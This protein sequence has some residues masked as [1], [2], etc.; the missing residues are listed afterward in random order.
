M[1][2]TMYASF[3]LVLIYAVETKG[4]SSFSEPIGIYED[5]AQL[6][7]LFTIH[8]SLVIIN[9]LIYEVPC[10]CILCGRNLAGDTERR[11]L[12]G[13]SENRNLAGD[14]ERRNLGG[15]SENRNLAGD[16]E[17]RNLGGDSENRNLAGDTERR[18]LGGDSEN[19]NLA[20]DTENRN[21]GGS[22]ESRNLAGDTENRNLGGNSETR[23]L[24]GNSENRNLAGQVTELNCQNISAEAFRITGINPNSKI[25]FYD[26][27]HLKSIENLIVKF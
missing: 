24:G 15:D 22:S 11:N 25:L 19:R 23:N 20:G 12:G 17:R 4:Q 7:S 6:N 5:S 21:L 26:G 13:D 3:V 16:T 27:L 10:D 1:M 9:N 2:K 18:N 8:G 14:T